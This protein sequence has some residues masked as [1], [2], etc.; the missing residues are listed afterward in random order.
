MFPSTFGDAAIW[1]GALCSFP[2]C[3][4]HLHEGRCR[5]DGNFTGS[6]AVTG[7]PRGGPITGGA[8][9]PQLAEGGPMLLGELRQRD[10]QSMDALVGR[11]RCNQS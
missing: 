4:C 9:T 7:G 3:H 5:P 1:G 6:S 8:G 2:E 11:T 10:P